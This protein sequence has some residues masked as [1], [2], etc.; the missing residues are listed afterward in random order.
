MRILLYESKENS[1]ENHWRKLQFDANT[2][3]FKVYI[4]WTFYSYKFKH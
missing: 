1:Q 2:Y 4:N 3:Y